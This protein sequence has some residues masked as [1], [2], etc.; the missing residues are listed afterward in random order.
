MYE[1]SLTFLFYVAKLF[2]KT[3]NYDK[4]R[5]VTTVTPQ[6]MLLIILYIIVIMSKVCGII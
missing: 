6:K 4:I 2:C 1:K 5:N 3:D